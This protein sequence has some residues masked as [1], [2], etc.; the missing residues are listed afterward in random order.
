MAVSALNRSNFININIQSKQIA[1]SD[2]PWNFTS[3]TSLQCPVTI[4]KSVFGREARTSIKKR[5]KIVI[6]EGFDYFWAIFSSQTPTTR[7]TGQI[8]T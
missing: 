3:K 8:Y 1:Y 6:F 7:Y 2:S 4:F 5:G